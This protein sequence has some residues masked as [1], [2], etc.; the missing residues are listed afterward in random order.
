MVVAGSASKLAD[1]ILLGSVRDVRVAGHVV[2]NP[3]DIAVA[4]LGFIYHRRH[5]DDRIAPSTRAGRHGQPKA[6]ADA[7][8]LQL[9]GL[10]NR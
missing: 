1:R 7:P 9:A 6:G 3:A 2:I 4:A 8:R 10:V 5:L